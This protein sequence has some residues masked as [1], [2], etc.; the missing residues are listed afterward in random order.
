MDNRSD[1]NLE[2]LKKAW[3]SQQFHAPESP[4]PDSSRLSTYSRKLAGRFRRTSIIGFVMAVAIWGLNA[5]L[6]MPLWL[7]SVESAF[8]VIMGLLQGSMWLKMSEYDLGQL[9]V[10][11]AIRRVVGIRKAM[12]RR[13][14][15]GITMGVPL[16]AAMLWTFF[17][18]DISLFIAGCVGMVIGAAIGYAKWRQNVWCIRQMER[19]LEPFADA[20]RS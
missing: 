11:E 17:S 6:R 16:L 14:A 1:L 7:V 13:I 5:Q 8:F 4:G 2:T 9:S 10:Q 12:A 19:E 20:E 3:Q 15:A 18:Q